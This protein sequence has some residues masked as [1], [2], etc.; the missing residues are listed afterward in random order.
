[1][2]RWR[3]AFAVFLFLKGILCADAEI[4]EPQA[5]LAVVG[6]AVQP[7]G[8]PVIIELVV[9][10]TGTAPMSFWCGGPGEYPD[11]A[12][13]S[14]I[15]TSTLGRDEQIVLANGQHLQGNGRLISVVPGGVI[16]V[17]AALG[18][19]APGSYRL[20]VSGG[21]QR[22]DGAA[23]GRIVT[24]PVTQT[25][26]GFEFQVSGDAACLAARD[27]QIIADVRANRAF[28]KFVTSK[29]PTRGQ[30]Q[31]LVSDLTGDD[32][33]AADRAAEGLWQDNAPAKEDGP[34]L[35]KVILKHLA[36]HDGEC[37]VGL[38]TRLTGAAQSLD[39][40]PVKSAM[41][42]LVLARPEG[43]VRRAAAAALDN[44]NQSIASKAR[45]QLANAAADPAA[46]NEQERRRHDAEILA[47]MLALAQSEDAHER[48][49]AYPALAAY[50]FSPAAV[51]AVR[52]GQQDAD[53]ECQGVAARAMR[54]I[55]K[56]LAE[57]RP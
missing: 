39:S 52:I 31:A 1:M 33:V 51:N 29:W 44:Q 16:R 37:D 32:I 4:G 28:A 8:S 11:A 45:F 25:A 24:W 10:N 22:W 3:I 2:N 41:A 9:R 17:P 49:L 36:P 5:S 56:K 53:A 13:Y 30:R 38:M 18:I 55:S 54:I 35:A 19:V 47:A 48:K 50:P 43:M 20:L 15:I 6:D 14:A 40:E 42:R 26:H 7:A 46:R 57:T 12:D 23:R 21:Q 27:A 34:L